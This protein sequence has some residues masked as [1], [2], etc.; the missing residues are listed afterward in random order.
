MSSCGSH[1]ASRDIAAGDLS[2]P[3]PI[4]GAEA[5]LAGSF[6]SM[7]QDL[8]RFREAM[9]T[10]QQGL[11]RRVQERT[12]ELT[13]VRDYL[14]KTNRNLTALNGVSAILSQCLYLSETLNAALG[15]TLEA[16]EAESGGIY[17]VGPDNDLVLTA[18]QGMPP[19]SLVHLHNL[20]AQEGQ[21]VA[22]LTEEA[23]A[24][25]NVCRRLA[26]AQLRYPSLLCVPLKA[27][28]RGLGVLFVA[29]G[30]DGRFTPEDRTLL[31]SIAW[32]IALTVRN[33]RLYDDLQ[34]EERARANLL[35]RVIAAQEDERKR[36][37]RELHDETSQALTALMVGLDTPVGLAKAREAP[38]AGRDQGHRGDAETFTASPDLRPSLGRPGAGSGDHLVRRAAAP[39]VG[40]ALP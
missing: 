14:L 6:E 29:D 24:S 23:S 1:R 22:D 28:G 38:P 2:H 37:A 9:E 30:K 35:H 12:A 17:L 21:E 8:L 18:H 25:D 7:R 32:Q 16:V 36:I 27:K 3:V 33:A 26:S 19:E 31:S 5:A 39:P 40:I 13:Q 15:R 10:D 20:A 11:E 4:G 34:R